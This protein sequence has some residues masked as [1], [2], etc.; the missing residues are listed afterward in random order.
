[1][2]STSAASERPFVRRP[3]LVSSVVAVAAGLIAVG[4]IVETT[5]QRRL[6]GAT[7][8][9]VAA[10]AFGGRLWKRGHDVTGAVL[11]LCGSVLVVVTLVYTASQPP[12]LVGR[13]EL[14]PGLLGLWILVAALVPIRFR[15][16]RLCI[17]VGTGLLFVSVLTS[18]VARGASTAALV[19]A[20]AATIL[21]WDAAENAVSIGHQIGGDAIR[22]TV[23]GELVHVGLSVA[24][25]GVAAVVILGVES[26]G[27]DGLPFAALVALLVA[28]LAFVLANR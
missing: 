16:S 27:I 25:A 24:V 4:L 22:T 14:L 8:V 13:L 9:G 10:F 1:M 6:L 2:T 17:D 12:R 19:I 20:A 15:W 5:G 28:V 11:A 26:V 18:G 7:M 3:T 23:G 21:A